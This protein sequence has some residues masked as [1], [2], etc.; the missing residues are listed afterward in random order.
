M[1]VGCDCCTQVYLL[2]KE[3]IHSN[4]SLV[5]S[6]NNF[7]YVKLLQPLYQVINEPHQENSCSNTVVVYRN[8]GDKE[9]G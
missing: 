9:V 7:V 3:T 5:C 2:T 1:I 6:I 8:V 4:P